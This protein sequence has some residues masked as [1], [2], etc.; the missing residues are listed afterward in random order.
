LLHN[1][2]QYNNFILALAVVPTGP[3]YRVSERCIYVRYSSAQ[4][5]K[6][7]CTILC[8]N[9]YIWETPLVPGDTYIVN[10]TSDTLCIA[11]RAVDR[12]KQSANSLIN[13]INFIIK[14]RFVQGIDL[15]GVTQQ[16]TNFKLHV[17]M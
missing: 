13:L 5:T 11:R 3:T 4:C 9:S 17:V 12:L 2:A 15:G 1:F 8:L 6:N 16:L 14:Y 7:V 10:N